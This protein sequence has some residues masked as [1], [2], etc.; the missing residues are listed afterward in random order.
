MTKLGNALRLMRVALGQSL[1]ETLN[2]LQCGLVFGRAGCTLGLLRF[3]LAHEL[4]LEMR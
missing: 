4:W 3:D 1:L 2:C